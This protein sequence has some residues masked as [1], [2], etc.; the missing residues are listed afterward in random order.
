MPT[1][2]LKKLYTLAEYASSAG[3]IFHIVLAGHPELDSQLDALIWHQLTPDA[4]V[5]YT[6]SPLTP[7]ACRA[8]VY[9]RLAQATTQAETVF[10][11]R[12]LIQ[13]IKAARGVPETLNV[14]CTQALIAGFWAQ[15]RPVSTRI[16][17]EAIAQVQRLSP[18]RLSH[19]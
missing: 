14:L 8:Y 15:R 16:A 12:A 4:V 19:R 6:L 17:R 13:I 1:L 10:T 9:H 2:T 11:F 3:A 18:S 5:R 7:K